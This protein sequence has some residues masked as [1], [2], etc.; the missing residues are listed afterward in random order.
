[1][2][3]SGGQNRTQGADAESAGDA[4]VNVVHTRGKIVA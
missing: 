3:R 4:R 2:R 1:M